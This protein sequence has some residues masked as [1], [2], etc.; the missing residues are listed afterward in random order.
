MFLTK[1]T[2]L[3]MLITLTTGWLQA[4]KL[5]KKKYQLKYIISPVDSCDLMVDYHLSLEFKPYNWFRKYIR[6]YISGEVADIRT[7]GYNQKDSTVSFTWPMDHWD[8]SHAL[9]NSCFEDIKKAFNDTYTIL[10]EGE[11][12]KLKNSRYTIVLGTWIK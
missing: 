11:E 12:L 5:D 6:C 4:Q 3:V 8:H 10:V 7:I 1:G 9:Y 2:I